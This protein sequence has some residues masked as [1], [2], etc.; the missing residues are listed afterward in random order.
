MG[1]ERLRPIYYWNFSVS[2]P[3]LEKIQESIKI[4]LENLGL[5][6]CGYLLKNKFKKEKLEVRL[7]LVDMKI[8]YRV[9]IDLFAEKETNDV[10]SVKER[11]EKEI[12]D[13]ID[14]NLI[15][16]KPISGYYL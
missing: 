7:D 16:K 3:N 5:V 4:S 15:L 12:Y 2:K 1:S 14:K 10:I 13:N 9:K 11:I 8:L 6:E